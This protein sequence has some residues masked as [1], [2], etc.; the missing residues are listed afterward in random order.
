MPTLAVE[1]LGESSSHQFAVAPLDGSRAA[2]QARPPANGRR[3]DTDYAQLLS[4]ETVGSFGF[5]PGVAQQRFDLLTLGC[6]NECVSELRVIGFRPAIDVGGQYQVGL[7]VA[8][9]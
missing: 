2:I 7:R 3:E 9:G 1:F 6:R 5:I 4:T 8:D